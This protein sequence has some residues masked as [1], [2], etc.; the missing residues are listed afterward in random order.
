[1]KILIVDD[2]AAN[3]KLLRFQLEA[4]GHEVLDAVNGI[5]A[6]KI[7]ELEAV[8]GV[9]S[10][11]LMPRMDGYLLCL[12]VRKDK[13]FSHLPLVLYTS[14]YNSPTDREL[15]RNAGA[16]AYIS[17]PAPTDVIIAALQAAARAPRSP[18]TSSAPGEIESPILRQYSETLVRKLEDKSTEL[19][20][21]CQGLAQT[22]AR[23]SGLIES[24]LDAII[25]FDEQQKIVLFNAAAEAM[26]GCER[27]TTLHSPLSNFFPSPLCQAL[28][29]SPDTGQTGPRLLRALRRDGSE[30]TIEASISSLDSSQGRLY[31]MFIRDITERDRIGRALHESEERFRSIIEASQDW[32]W[33][34]D[35]E[36]RLIYT[37]NAVQHILGYSANELLGHNV[38]TLIHPE[39]RTSVIERIPSFLEHPRPWRRQP[40]RWRHRNGGVHVLHS[41][42]NPVLDIDGRVIGYRGANHDDTERLA[43]EARISRLVHIHAVLSAIGNIVV[44][45]SD[46]NELLHNACRVAVDQGGF[47]A[48][49]IGEGT[50]V[51][52]LRV[53]ASYGDAA[54]LHAVAP[55]EPM[56]VNAPGRYYPHPGIRAFREKHKIVIRDFTAADVPVELREEMKLAGVMSEVALPLGAEP[57]GILTLFSES[58]RDYDEEEI[59]LLE[60]LAEE[61]DH[62]GDFIAKS[63]RLEYLAYH[64]PVTGLP[65]RSAFREHVQSML[66]CGPVIVCVLDVRRFAYIND[67]RGRAFG[68]HC[69]EQIGV[70]LRRIFA[71]SGFVAHPEGC[72]FLLAY[73][74]TDRLS[75]EIERLHAQLRRFENQAFTIDGE[76]IYINPQGGVAIAPQHGDNG[77]ILERNGMSALAEAERRDE[78][79]Y[80]FSENLQGRATRRLKLE[81]DLRHALDQG[82]FEL[83]YQPKFLTVGNRLLGAEALLRWRRPGGLIQPAEFIS[84]LE[85]TG[86]IVPVGQYVLRDALAHAVDW[87]ARYQPSL[88]I[89]VN[90]S[91]RELRDSGFLDRYRAILEPHR[92]DQGIDIEITESLLM[93]DIDRNIPLL[94]KLRELGCHI[95]IDDFGTGYSSLN[96][97]TRL[98]ADEI[99]ID[100]SFVA[101]LTQ[102][103]ETLGLITNII[104]LAHSL[105][106]RVVAE[107]VETEEQAK[108]LH[109]L[110]CDVVQGYFLGRPM[111]ADVF[112]EVLANLSA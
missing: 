110:R 89:A 45:A 69:L 65:N 96:Y 102:S 36:G 2:Q 67:S 35:R 25:A 10:D 55:E 6:L 16:D 66:A 8:D 27:A 12:E 52:T 68:D 70:R 28:I 26:F 112:E 56:H 3:L 78:L 29:G 1:M 14:T 105:S 82:E 80:V 63:E 30:F 5:E 84:V 62:A 109:L 34:V 111:P 24:A 9:V 37:N 73:P 92:A 23:L 40:L 76:E 59:G 86:L 71:A 61:I 60:R 87:R 50:A 43:Q 91:A 49:C 93:D 83:Y 77:E 48:A 21:A 13:R 90:V 7:L 39:D 75:A 42:A 95:S 57:W 72:T 44:R 103:P 38:M 79:L 94:E 74:I 85:E 107:G 101:T 32:I 47:R 19:E 33:E 15:A 31:T 58:A 17:K 20:R 64:N 53:A 88:R 54:I 108:L 97:L 81:H 51:D 98:P 104:N 22:E 18:A 41:T 4:E 11:I 46:R 106:L 99:K 100:Q